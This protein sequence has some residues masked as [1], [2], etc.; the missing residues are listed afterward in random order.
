MQYPPTF[1][2]RVSYVRVSGR[3]DVEVPSR[4]RLQ[5]MISLANKQAT[6]W[7]FRCRSQE[8]EAAHRMR[9]RMRMRDEQEPTGSVGASIGQ[10]MRDRG[11]N[12]CWPGIRATDKR[13]LSRTVGAIG[14]VR[15]FRSD[16]DHRHH[17]PTAWDTQ[18]GLNNNQA[19]IFGSFFFLFFSF[20]HDYSPA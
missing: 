2:H 18:R 7:R 1:V 20:W 3:V 9:M 11:L 6:A 14:T 5:V 4:L 8:E 16:A 13:L 19:M 17:H 10:P 12:R 15:P